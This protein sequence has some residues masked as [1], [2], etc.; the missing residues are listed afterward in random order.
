M[1]PLLYCYNACLHLQ[2]R[3][4]LSQ[5]KKKHLLDNKRSKLSDSQQHEY[6]PLLYLAELQDSDSLRLTW[7]E[8]KLASDDNRRQKEV[9]GDKQQRD[10][11]CYY[12]SD[13]KDH[14][15]R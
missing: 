1:E 15:W 8:S 4:D 14:S 7:S 13:A 11:D 10:C 6:L 3:C 9:G 12:Y 5:E 2:A